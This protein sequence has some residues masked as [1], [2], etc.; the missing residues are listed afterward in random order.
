MAVNSYFSNLDS[1]PPPSPCALMLGAAA[2][3]AQMGVFWARF[4]SL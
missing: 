2:A 3:E 1:L 4:F